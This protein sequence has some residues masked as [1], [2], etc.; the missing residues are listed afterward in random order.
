MIEIE[1]IGIKDIDDFWKLH[2]QY[3][4]D[5]DIISDKEDIDYFS[6]REYRGVIE[7]HMQRENNRH[8]IVWFK[9]DGKRIGAASF[10]IYNTEDGKC[11]ILDFWVFPLFRGNGTGHRSFETLEKYASGLGAVYYEL[12]STKENSVRFW[13]SLGFIENGED[14]YGLPLFI[15]K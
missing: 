1:E 13:K 9:E 6:G 7:S 8:R 12:N 3:L 11:F 14:E 15:K 5:D 4:I 10:C 2:I